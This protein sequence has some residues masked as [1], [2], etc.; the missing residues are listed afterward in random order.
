M[1]QG[2]CGTS[3]ESRDSW[4]WEHPGS[5]DAGHHGPH[6]QRQQG[7]F[8]VPMDVNMNYVSRPELESQLLCTLR[9]DHDSSSRSQRS[10]QSILWLSGD[11]WAKLLAG[12][13]RMLR[14]AGVPTSTGSDVPDIASEWLQDNTGWLLV[15]DNLDDAVVLDKLHDEVLRANMK[16]SILITSRNDEVGS[17]W[18]TIEVA[19]MTNAESTALIKVIAGS[20]RSENE[21]TLD[22]LND[23]GH[24]ALAV[25]QAASYMRAVNLTVAQYHEL[26]KVAKSTYLD[27]YP[28]TRYNGMGRQSV[29]TTWNIS[30]TEVSRTT[31]QAAA[32]LLL[33]SLLEADD[34]PTILL[35]SQR[36]FRASATG[37]G[38]IPRELHE[39][40]KS[41]QQIVGA[42]REL[43]RFGF[44][45]YQTASESL[46]MHPLVQYWACQRLEQDIALRQKLVV[47]LLG[48][49]SSSFEKQDMLPP[50]L[51]WSDP[52]SD[53]NSVEE[54]KLDLWSWRKY[55]RLTS[56]AQQ[57]ILLAA[58]KDLL[59]N[60]WSLV[61]DRL[62]I[63][64]IAL[65]LLQVLEYSTFGSVSPNYQKAMALI[66]GCLRACSRSTGTAPG[67]QFS[68]WTA[69]TWR[70]RRSLFCTC[71]VKMG[72][73]IEEEDQ[74]EQD[75]QE[76]QQNETI[77]LLKDYSRRAGIQSD[78]NHTGTP[79]IVHY[80]RVDQRLGSEIQAWIRQ[81]WRTVHDYLNVRAVESD[82]RHLP[83]SFTTA[84]QVRTSF[85][86]FCGK[87][88]E[89]CRR[90]SYYEALELAGV[91]DK[92]ISLLEPYV[93]QT[94]ESPDVS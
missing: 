84:P 38:W 15:I 31:P 2:E 19:D 33:L 48:L 42:R 89:E 26:Y 81:Y 51:S 27:M 59:Q 32:L 57:C 56:H 87:L 79:R 67:T 63:A 58:D 29:M 30:F 37:Q 43:Q 74:E 5:P 64:H 20:T 60:S 21:A 52:S 88:S 83:D 46:Y 45:K 8:D 10:Y 49:V 24:L 94:I 44:V 4:Q 13:A 41:E 65:P 39:I 77:S 28:S 34:I 47:C 55:S 70:E 90:A 18:H 92:V 85:Q 11:S 40:L 78:P 66:D 82:R 61:S 68:I 3:V 23:L 22:L 7:L 16:G 54:R 6:R 93:A 72:L 62:T 73:R 17:Q 35:D 1:W 25:D 14:L 86:E 75:E 91:P 80:V 50:L 9:A 36:K 12:L 69:I 71:R 76:D 53:A